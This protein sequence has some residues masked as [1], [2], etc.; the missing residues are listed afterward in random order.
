MSQD[1]LAHTFPRELRLLVIAA[2]LAGLANLADFLIQ[3][4]H[5]EAWESLTTNPED[6][7]SPSVLGRVCAPVDHL[8]LF[9]LFARDE[10][11]PVEVA[12]TDNSLA[13]VKYLPETGLQ[14]GSHWPRVVLG[15]I[16]IV[17]VGGS[18]LVQ[19]CRKL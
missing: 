7:P 1:T 9:A 4:F 19:K 14:G 3:T 6:G 11:A 17:A 13:Q 15:V 2:L 10:T 16:V 5:N 18:I 12:S 8:T